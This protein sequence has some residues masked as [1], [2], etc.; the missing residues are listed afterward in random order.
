M[1]SPGVDGNDRNIVIVRFRA[2]PVH[3]VDVY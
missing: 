2:F 3:G 1:I